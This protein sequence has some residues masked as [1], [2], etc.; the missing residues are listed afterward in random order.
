[1]TNAVDTSGIVMD[2][3]SPAMEL[4][5]RNYQMHRMSDLGYSEADH[6]GI[7]GEGS[8]GSSSG[9]ADPAE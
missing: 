2:R 7:A 9:S 6:P 8:G 4:G 1:M 3:S 5:C